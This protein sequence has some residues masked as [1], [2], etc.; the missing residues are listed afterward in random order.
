M[1]DPD[2]QS[3]NPL[4]YTPPRGGMTFLEFLFLSIFEGHHLGDIPIGLPSEFISEGFQTDKSL[5]FS[6]D[7]RG[8]FEFGM[9][10]L[11]ALNKKMN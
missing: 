10:D 3:G 8:L 1:T 5:V 2:P 11:V 4:V 9:I 6:V 7:G